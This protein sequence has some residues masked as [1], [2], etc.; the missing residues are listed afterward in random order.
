MALFSL[1]NEAWASSEPH[2]PQNKPGAGR[3]D[4]RRVISGIVH[5]LKFSCRWCDCVADFGQ[6]TTICNRFNRWLPRG[7]W[8]QLLAALVDAGVVTSA[9]IDSAYI[10]IQRA[11]LVQKGALDASDWTI[12]WRLDHRNPCAYRRRR[13]FLCLDADAG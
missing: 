4:D 6:P 11:A 7:F 12:A 9:A 2:L 8:L 1:S 3:V 5:V 10:K 13:P